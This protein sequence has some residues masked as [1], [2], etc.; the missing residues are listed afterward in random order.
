M[1]ANFRHTLGEIR[2]ALAAGPEWLSGAEAAD[3]LG[4][5]KTTFN[6]WATEGRLVRKRV[7]PSGRGN[8]LWFY[9]RDELYRFACDMLGAPCPF[10]ESEAARTAVLSMLERWQNCATIQELHDAAGVMSLAPPVRT[11]ERTPRTPEPHE[12]VECDGCGIE[13]VRVVG[14]PDQCKRCRA[15]A[16]QR[17]R[18]RVGAFVE[19]A[20]R[21]A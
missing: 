16:A 11:F 6:T 12:T 21:G 17:V 9:R 15:I 20:K 13:F 4:I 2:A 1:A 5:S 19:W 7:A 3:A 10:D 18:R 8:H 14:G